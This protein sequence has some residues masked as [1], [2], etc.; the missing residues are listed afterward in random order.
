M[1]RELIPGAVTTLEHDC[2]GCGAP[3]EIIDRFTLWGVPEDVEHVKLRCPLGHWFTLP[4]DWLAHID[5]GPARSAHSRP[6]LD[7]GQPLTSATP[8]SVS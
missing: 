1:P 8:R 2:P 6:S 5:A 7:A 3:I 4:T